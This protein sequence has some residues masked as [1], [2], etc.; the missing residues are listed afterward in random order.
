VQVC[1]GVETVGFAGLRACFRTVGE[2]IGVV[3]GQEGQE[4]GFRRGDAGAA[5]QGPRAR[6]PC[7]VLRDMG[8]HPAGC[9]CY[10][11]IPP[12]MQRI[13]PVM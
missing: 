5:P 12:S 6:C 8:E 7:Y 11:A 3:R 1:V 9:P 2:E 4:D 10:I 13:W